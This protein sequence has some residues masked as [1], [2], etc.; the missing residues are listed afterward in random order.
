MEGKNIYGTDPMP[1][2]LGSFRDG[3]EILN[4]QL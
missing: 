4:L 1:R 3:F 2:L